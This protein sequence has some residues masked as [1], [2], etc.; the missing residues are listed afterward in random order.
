LI[1]NFDYPIRI[2]RL[3]V[4][5]KAKAALAAIRTNIHGTSMCFLNNPNSIGQFEDC[6]GQHRKS[7]ENFVP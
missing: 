5:L 7:P 4:P 6:Y 1:I 3:H 2:R